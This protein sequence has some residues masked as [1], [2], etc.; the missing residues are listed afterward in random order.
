MND[1]QRILSYIPPSELTYT[2]WVNVGMALKAEGF[3]C[4]VWD[5]WSR[6]DRRYHPGECERKWET[7]NGAQTPVTGGTLVQMAKEVAK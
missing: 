2:E 6:A 4:A 5:D 7:F 3:G 1:I